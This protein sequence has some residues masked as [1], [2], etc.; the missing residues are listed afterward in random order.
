[1]RFSICVIEPAG[2]RYSH[3]LYDICRYLCFSIES[4]GFECCILRNKLSSDR[5]NI[6]AGAHNGTDPAIVE[7]IRK[8]NYILGQSE[9]ITGDSVNNWANQK[10]FSEVYLPL[11]RHAQAV[12]TGIESNIEA[13]S[14]LGIEADQILIGYHPFME[15]IHHKQ[16]K[17]I[18]F[19]FC[20]SIT[21]HRRKLLD[22]L[23]A[24]GAKVVTMFDDAAMY[25][26][27][28][29]ARSRIN[30]APNQG[31]DMDH[32]SGS[33]IGYLLN[34]RAVVVVER[35]RDQAMYEHC[36][37]WADTKQWVDLCM[38]TL[39]RPDFTEIADEYYERFKKMP[40]ADFIAPLIDRFLSKYASRS[41]SCIKTATDQIMSANDVN[42]NENVII[43]KKT[44]TGLTSI[45]I[46]TCNGLEFTK[47]CVKSIQNHT[48]EAHEIIFVD[49][50]STDNTVLWI[51]RHVKENKNCKLIENKDDPGFAKGCNL[52]IEVSEGE[53]ILLLNNDVEVSEGWLRGMLKCFRAVPEAGIIGPMANSGTGLQKA[54]LDGRGKDEHP[55]KIAPVFYEKYRNRRIPHR[56][57]EGF[58][59]LIHRSIIEKTGLLDETF[60]TGDFADEDLCLRA[61]LVGYQNYIAADVYVRCISDKIPSKDRGV[62][63]RKWTLSTAKP[64]GKKLAVLRATEIADEIYQKGDIDQAVEA[65]VN[66]I[67]ISPDAKEIYYALVRFFIETKRF[68]EARDVVGAM[69]EPLRESIKGL[70]CSAYAKEGLNLDDEAAALTDK[71]LELDNNYPAALNLK[72]ILEYKKGNMETA[73]SFF[74]GA[75]DSDPGYAEPYTNLG[76][77]YWRKEKHDEALAN[78]RRGFILSPVVPD[79]NS[80]YYSVASALGQYA[81]A[82]TELRNAVALYPNNKNLAFLLIDSL[83]Q[84]GKLT[85]AIFEV[86]NTLA[87][88]GLDEGTL[89]AALSIRETIGPLKTD[90]SSRKST[91][92]LC[93]IVKNE[94]KHLVKCLQSVRDVVDEIIIVDTGSTDKTIDISRVFGAQVFEFPWTG[95]FSAARNESLNKASGNWILVLDAD[96]VISVSDLKE[97]RKIVHKKPSSAEAY[98]IVTRNYLRNVG[99]IGWTQNNGEYPEEAGAG[100]VASTKVR[101]FTRNK[102]A[103]FSN[104]VHETLEH[105][106]LNAKVP[107]RP[108][109]IVVHHY[110][111][112]DE[113]KD[114][115][116]GEDYY[117][118]GRIKYESDPTN[119]KYVMELAKQAQVLNKY[120]ETAELW[121][122]LETLIKTNPDS[123]SYKDIARVC[124]GDPLSEVY[125]QLSSAYLMLERY[126]EAL[127][128]ASKAIEGK[129]KLKEYVHV[130]AHCEMIAGSPDKAFRELEELLKTEPDYPPAL[131][132]TAVIYNLRGEKE[133]AGKILQKLLQ[134][135]MQMEGLFNKYARQFL[136]MGKN[137]EALSTLNIA[138]ENEIRNK[139]TERLLNILKQV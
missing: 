77:L 52:G 33:R 70:E 96:E 83:I 39:N 126:D 137:N 25:R 43:A 55:D 65:L 41:P 35:C 138:I 98:S 74:Q 53:F 103:F 132:L 109:R 118:L 104:P 94:E 40:M 127:A 19:L 123:P 69:P 130:Y 75:I 124:F 9:I 119:M 115:K 8:T 34:N 23:V 82:E 90:R 42:S 37:P 17:D 66:C 131:L 108:C 57:L 22:Q 14:N 67:K 93:M 121:L 78:L 136:A 128:T 47:R 91:L 122:Q 89:N 60:G 64:E 16:K 32:F 20:G 84:Q 73:Q 88:F 5:I 27:D 24:R 21:S 117:L 7:Q 38:E 59:M 71:M 113:H 11:M 107:I 10:S 81:E 110:G 26:N 63:N 99:V 13:L 30:L 15:E 79:A 87:L 31:S 92:S 139:E 1:M 50:G 56:K 105:S 72:G 97:L 80:L 134:R 46:I 120:E 3:F 45:I 135:N 29:I 111:K 106:L 44:I 86:E 18:D 36:F 49:N 68:P 58:C 62:L 28:L 76:V 100:W 116:K 51:K 125:A 61:A 112:L 54:V 4:L 48:P 6:I 95:D 102:N 12:W 85:E 101:L 129:N 2:Y 114:L 133:K